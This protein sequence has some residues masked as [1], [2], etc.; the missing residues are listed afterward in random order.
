[1][2]QRLGKPAHT[3]LIANYNKEKYISRIYFM[4]SGS[5]SWFARLQKLVALFTAESEIYAAIDGTKVIAH[6]KVLLTDLGA[7]DNSPVTTYQDNQA[8]IQM[9]S[10]LRNHKNARHYVARL[11]YL[12]Q[13]VANETIKFRDCHIRDQLADIMTKPLSRKMTWFHCKA[14]FSNISRN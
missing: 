12:Q 4:K 2:S 8:C 1:M 14:M 9:G 6:L 10:Q 7:R 11:S 13:Q 5:I 3:L